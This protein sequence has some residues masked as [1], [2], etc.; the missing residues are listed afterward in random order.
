M[1]TEVKRMKV[2]MPDIL[3]DTANDMRNPSISIA[4]SLILASMSTIAKEA[5]KIENTVILEEL[6]ILGIVS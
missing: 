5:I 6:R 3:I 2:N 1:A 4:M